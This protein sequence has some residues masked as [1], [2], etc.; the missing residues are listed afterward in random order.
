MK[1]RGT[2]AAGGGTDC[3][4]VA[5]VGTE[6]S[7]TKE[8]LDTIAAQLRFPSYFGHN[9]DALDECLQDLS[10]LPERVIAIRHEGIPPIAADELLTYLSILADAAER[11]NADATHELDVGFPSPEWAVVERLT[12]G[13]L[14]GA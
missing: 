4:I 5:V 14:R 3:P 2:A 6:V 10:W 12:R 11:W 1:E 7:T 9:W 8:L 13:R